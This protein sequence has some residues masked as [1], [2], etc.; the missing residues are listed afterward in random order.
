MELPE[1]YS[2]LIIDETF[3]QVIKRVLD[4][5]SLFVTGEAGTG[6]S[7]LLKIL[8]DPE[9]NGGKESVILATTGVAASTI[10]GETFHSFFSIPPH[11]VDEEEA[12][13][14]VERLKRYKPEKIKI[15]HSVDMIFIDE[16]SMLKPY[17][18]D[19]LDK[20]LRL[21]KSPTKQF[22]GAQ[23]ILFGDLFQLEP[24]VS[25][26]D[27]VD[28]LDDVYE[29]IPYF[30]S[31][32]TLG[33]K[34]MDT[35]QLKTIYRQKDDK[36]FSEMLRRIRF[37]N[38]TQ[39]DIQSINNRIVSEEDFYADGDFIHLCSTNKTAEYKNKEGLQL[40]EGDLYEFE[41]VCIDDVPKQTRYER[42]LEL[43]IGA[44]VML[45]KNK[46]DNGLCNGS[47][48]EILNIS[49]SGIK[50]LFNNGVTLDIEKDTEHF[51]KYQYDKE[52]KKIKKGQV[53][54]L[55]QYPLKLAYAIT[56]HKAQGLT[57]DRAYVNLGRGA[58]AAGQSYV[59]LSRVRNMQSLGLHKKL[60]DKDIIVSK[61]LKRFIDE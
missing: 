5:E 10:G 23:I 3:A 31:A 34:Q 1:K 13:S 30:F 52:V 7:E 38:H 45:L 40:L 29:G 42:H 18:M 35:V 59:A 16:V 21:C 24:V 33:R 9:V 43:K 39:Q 6:K 57:L 17:H 55:R 26:S 27:E 56:I 32:N 22:G 2:H 51:F 14:I 36:V 20:I 60:N 41:A 49:N 19:I 58:F 11:P 12:D 46:L 61:H 54:E 8:S 4:G 44:Q 37:K 15:Y 28:F 53:G 48:G 47:M 25:S 50:V